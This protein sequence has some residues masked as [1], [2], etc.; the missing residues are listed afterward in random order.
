M[1]IVI[2]NRE[3]PELKKYL[4]TLITDFNNINLEETNL[5]V[6]DIHIYKDND[7][8]PS[9]IFERKS[10]GD[11]LSSIKDG[12]YTEQSYR[13]EEYPLSNHN[14]YYIIEGSIEYLRNA[15]QKQTIYSSIFT[16]NHFKGFSVINSYNIKQM[17]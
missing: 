16:L 17:L 8:N 9:I 12:R 6:G 11:L 7:S 3:P 4:E 10:L 15:N 14:I 1:K 5:D 13:L 2:D